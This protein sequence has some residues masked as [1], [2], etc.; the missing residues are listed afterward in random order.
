MVVG[1]AVTAA[2]RPPPPK[3]TP[4]PKVTQRQ[5]DRRRTRAGRRWPTKVG[6]AQRPDRAGADELLTARRARQ[7]L[8]EQKVALAVSQLQTPQAAAT[9]PR[10]PRSVPQAGSVGEPHTTSSSRYMQA[11]LCRRHGRRGTTGSLLTAPG[12]ERA[13][14]A[15]SALRAVPGQRARSTR[16]AQMQT[17]TVA[18]SNAEA[19]ARRAVAGHAAKTAARRSRPKPPRPSEVAAAQVQQQQLQAAQA[20]DADAAGRRAG[21]AGD[22]EPPA[23]GVPRVQVAEQRRLAAHRPGQGG[24]RSGGTARSRASSRAAPRRAHRNHHGGGWRAVAAAA[25]SLR[26]RAPAGGRLDRGQ[27]PD[28]PS[29]APQLAGHALQRGPA[30]T[31]YGPTAACCDRATVRRATARSRLR[32]LRAGDV[33]LGPQLGAL[34]GHA[35]LRRPA[36]YHPGRATSSPATC[37]SGAPAARWAA[38][39][40]S[41]STSATATSSGAVERRGHQDHAVA[42]CT[43]PATSA[44]PAR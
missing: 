25:V 1:A 28:A 32:L 34:R 2:A 12:P 44:P 30:A 24:R 21:A 23:H 37:S 40:T 26:S 31:Q 22:P 43:S 7:E 4:P 13:A 3:P 27:G 33:R 19:A 11:V 20:S 39:T 10:R 41:R 38:S 36:R 42:A 18:Q 6:A 16:S 35:V 17:A 9:T 29:A 8:A 14:R 15:A 5:V